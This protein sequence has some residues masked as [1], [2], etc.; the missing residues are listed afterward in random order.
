LLLT[1]AKE[2]AA[3][4]SFSFSAYPHI[5]GPEDVGE[6]VDSGLLSIGGTVDNEDTDGDEWDKG[7]GVKGVR[8]DG[9]TSIEL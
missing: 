9:G 7:G 4:E 1:F 5:F 6:G 8:G 3:S 2:A